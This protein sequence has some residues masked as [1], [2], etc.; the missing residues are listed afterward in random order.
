MNVLPKKDLKRKIHQTFTSSLLKKDQQFP[1]LITD[2]PMEITSL[3]VA[4]TMEYPKVKKKK[5]MHNCTLHF[6]NQE[7]SPRKRKMQREIKTLKEKLRRKN[8]KILSLQ[9]LLKQLR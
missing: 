9:N 4:D 7:I 1:T 6:K 5:I 3:N 2:V 8:N